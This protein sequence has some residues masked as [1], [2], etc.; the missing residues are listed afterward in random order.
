M[1]AKVKRCTLPD[2]EQPATYPFKT[3]V[4]DRTRTQWYCAEHWRKRMNEWQE[5]QL[6][7][8]TS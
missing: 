7:S 3:K 2:C 5:S 1:G 8:L 4:L 6:K